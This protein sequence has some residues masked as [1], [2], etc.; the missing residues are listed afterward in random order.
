MLK[1]HSSS[2]HHDK[3][4]LAALLKPAPAALTT[5]SPLP[6]HSLPITTSWP[7]AAPA[8]SQSPLVVLVFS[9]IQAHS[10][11]THILISTIPCWHVMLWQHSCTSYHYKPA[12]AAPPSSSFQA[13]F[14]GSHIITTT[15]ILQQHSGSTIHVGS[16]SIL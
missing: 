14:G 3:P 12:P 13:R 11:S 6:W 15:S 9:A 1:A 7:L 8:P 5:S 2:T 10:C 4:A 16:G